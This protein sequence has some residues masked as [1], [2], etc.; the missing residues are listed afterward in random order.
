M[1]AMILSIAN[2]KG[3]VGKT[4]TAVNLSA[5]LGA[6]EKRVLLVDMDPQGNA[7]SGYGIDRASLTRSVYDLLLGEAP[8]SV[9]IKTA[10]PQVD[11]IPSAMALAGAEIEMVEMENR[12]FLLGEGLA[13]IREA[14]DFV[15]VDCPPSLGLLTLNALSAADALL[16]PLQCEYYALEG[17]SH[18]M[19]TVDLVRQRLNPGLII[20]G[21]L[22]TMFDG[23][24]NLASQVAEEA[25]RHFGDL[26]YE[27]IVPRNVRLGE[28]PSHG[29]PVLFYDIRSKGAQSYLDLAKEVIRHVEKSAGQRTFGSY[30]G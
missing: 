15:L 9:I 3:G 23:R 1:D 7:T 5:S 19:K 4:T 6:A 22:L 29:M 12:E 25:R 14:Y 8:G 28:S 10:V 21:I 13:G 11:L 17:L 16:V 26:V 24:N 27:T 20:S 18:L 30:T 2:Q